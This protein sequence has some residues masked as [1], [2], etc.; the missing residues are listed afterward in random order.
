MTTPSDPALLAGRA[1]FITG[2][3]R[4]IGLAVARA[5]LEAGASVMLADVLEGDLAASADELRR[6]HGDRLAVSFLDVTDEAGTE[7][8]IEAMQRRF[9]RLDIAVPNA[10]ILVLKHAVDLSLPEW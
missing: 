7:A 2:A 5:Y 4:G 3:A 1:A 6:A 10:G 9:G 8:T